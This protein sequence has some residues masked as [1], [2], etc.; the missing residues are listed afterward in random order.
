[1]EMIEENKDLQIVAQ[2]EISLKSISSEA[3]EFAFKLTLKPTVKLG[4]YKGL[5]VKKIL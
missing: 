1:M 4:K 3:V 5:N 2:P